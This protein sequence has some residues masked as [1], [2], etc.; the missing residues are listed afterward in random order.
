MTLGTVFA[1]L[2]SAA[3]AVCVVAGM[4]A[5]PNPS[6][7]RARVLPYMR[8]SATVLGLAAPPEADRTLRGLMAAA[9]SLL[10]GSGDPALGRKLIQARVLR[11]L[12]PAA[13]LAAYRSRVGLSAAAA[14]TV[15][16]SIAFVAGAALPLVVVVAGLGVAAGGSFWRGRLDRAI[17]ARRSLMR[18]ELYTINQLLAM[19]VRAGSGVVAATRRLA[20]R[21][22]GE[23]VA[24]LK[25][26]LRLHRSGVPAADA[27]RRVAATAPEPHLVRTFN[28]LASAEER[29]ADVARALLALSEDVREGRREAI[30]RRATKR[31]AAML[32]PV[33]GLLAPTLILFVAAPLPWLV[34]R[35]FGSS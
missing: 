30:R 20:D 13:R 14:G 10:E 33:L 21:G 26:A 32:L 9:G 22:R 11:G 12:A 7:L 19:Y 1:V 23:V 29:G 18:I 28:A 34:L 3:S 6:R 5:I 24:E 31:R 35:G 17:A 8:P 27:F 25:E 15:A 16:L 4:A 2:A